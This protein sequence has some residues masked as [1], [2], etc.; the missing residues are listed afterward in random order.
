MKEKSIFG[1]NR[2]E[3]AWRTILRQTVI[4]V[5]FKVTRSKTKQGFNDKSSE[6]LKFSDRIALIT[7]WKKVSRESERCSVAFNI[8]HH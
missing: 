2:D 6:L 3:T 4:I 1:R 5:N 8:L 7:E